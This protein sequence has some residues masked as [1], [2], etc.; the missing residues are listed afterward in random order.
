ME[1]LEIRTPTPTPF[2]Q[3]CISKNVLEKTLFIRFQNKIP[4]K[5]NT[6]ED[7]GEG[8]C[9]KEGKENVVVVVRLL[10]PGFQ[11]HESELTRC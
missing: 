11:L 6:V 1:A 7:D 8:E 9:L 5:P 4:K 2:S 10:Y 3:K